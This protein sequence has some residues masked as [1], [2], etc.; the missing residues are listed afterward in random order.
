MGRGDP[1]KLI[2]DAHNRWLPERERDKRAV[3]RGDTET[4]T[5]VADTYFTAGFTGSRRA[6]MLLATSCPPGLVSQGQ[7]PDGWVKPLCARG[8]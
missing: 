8:C 3:N 4:D 7:A 1:Q 6:L 5:Y 2:A